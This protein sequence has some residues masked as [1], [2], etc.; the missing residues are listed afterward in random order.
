MTESKLLIEKGQ[1]VCTLTMNRPAVMNALDVEFVKEL[2][3]AF[4]SLESS[5]DVRVVVLQGAGGN[6]SSGADMS[7]LNAEHGAPE[8]LQGMRLVGKLVRTIREIPQPVITKVRGV[9][10]GG[11]ANL[12]LAGDFVVA[13]HDARFCQVFVNIGAITDMGGTYFLPRL[14]GLA[15]ARELAMLGEII[16]G[17]TAASIGL[18]YRSFPDEELDR[19]VDSLA[20]RLSQKSPAAMTLIKEGLEASLGMSLSEVLEWE[21]AH[22]AIMLQTKEHK[23]AVERYLRSRGKL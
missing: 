15:K 2:Q 23:E 20:S 19:E 7:F 4:A 9:A 21:A 3:E 13:S 11:G 10:V 22:Q 14:V 8:S 17:E 16:D 12:A 5:T 1:G 18:I 6:F